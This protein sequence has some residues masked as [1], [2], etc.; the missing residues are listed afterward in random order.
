M[1]GG[2]WRILV[3]SANMSM[4]FIICA[5]LQVGLFEAGQHGLHGPM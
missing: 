5:P 3:A 1:T 2:D 4:L